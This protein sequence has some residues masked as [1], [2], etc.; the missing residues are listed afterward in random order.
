[1]PP[2]GSSSSSSWPSPQ[3]YFYVPMKQCGRARRRRG[4]SR[5]SR[6]RGKA[7]VSG[8]ERRPS[9]GGCSD[10]RPPHLFAVKDVRLLRHRRRS[11]PARAAYISSCTTSGG[12]KHAIDL[13]P[14]TASSTTVRATALATSVARPTRRAKA[15]GQSPLL[16]VPAQAAHSRPSDRCA[17][18]VG[19]E[20]AKDGPCGASGV[21]G[22]SGGHLAF[23]QLRWTHQSCKGRHGRALCLRS[24]GSGPCRG[25]ASRPGGQALGGPRCA[26]QCARS[27][28]SI[29]R[30]TSAAS[31][32]RHTACGGSIVCA[33]LACS[34]KRPRM[35]SGG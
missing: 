30:A 31:P 25:H 3:T 2:P 11:V 19:D 34:S 21:E 14:S 13:P 28:G 24:G 29:S 10:G 22:V 17:H 12:R 1:M 16:R 8:S 9:S 26:N 32:A 18:E 6:G 23:G 33:L 27:R 5:S 35:A 4:G 15:T 7:K 20:E